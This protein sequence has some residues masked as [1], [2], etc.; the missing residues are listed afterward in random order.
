[1]KQRYRPAA[2]GGYDGLEIFRT[3]RLLDGVAGDLPTS[4]TKTRI[5]LYRP[6]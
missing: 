2:D 6:P 4:T 5:R 1:M 3:F